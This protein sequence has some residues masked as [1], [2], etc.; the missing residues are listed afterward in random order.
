MPPVFLMPSASLLAAPFFMTF[1]SLFPE[2]PASSF[3]PAMPSFAPLTVSV[4]VTV[5]FPSCPVFLELSIGYAVISRRYP[6]IVRRQFD[7]GTGN[8]S[9][10]HECPGT[11][12]RSGSEPTA[13]VGTIPIAA[14]TALNGEEERGEEGCILYVKKRR[15][16]VP[17]IRLFFLCYKLRKKAGAEGCKEVRSNITAKG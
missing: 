12:I 3:R 7:D 17:R 1:P 11:I 16:S 9:R 4:P 6:T 15:A 13:F 14:V 10:F 8:A 2:L 5:P